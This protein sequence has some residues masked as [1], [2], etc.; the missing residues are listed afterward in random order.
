MFSYINVTYLNNFFC[1]KLL[2]W[3]YLIE[4]CS[5]LVENLLYSATE[6]QLWLSSNTLQ[7]TSIWLSKI[8]DT[9]YITAVKIIMLRIDCINEIYSASIVLKVI[10]ICNLLHHNT[11]HP[12]CIITYSVYDMTFSYRHL[13]ETIH[14]QG[15][16]LRNTQCLFF[17]GIVN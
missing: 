9:F 7:K 12:T 4:M 16:C 5:V 14:R 6:M 3:W 15:R 10:S 8:I 13:L 2:K 11:W 1:M 17:I